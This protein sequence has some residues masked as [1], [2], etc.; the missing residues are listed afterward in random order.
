MLR[1]GG[2]FEEGV[3]QRIVH[4]GTCQWVRRYLMLLDQGLFDFDG[5]SFSVGRVFRSMSVEMPVCVCM[6][7]FD[8]RKEPNEI[9]YLCLT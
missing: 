5:I 6:A 8:L 3:E 1:C 2:K 7:H 4:P 9:S